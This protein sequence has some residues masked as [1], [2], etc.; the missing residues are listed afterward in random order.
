MTTSGPQANPNISGPGSTGPLYSSDQPEGVK[1]KGNVRVGDSMESTPKAGPDTSPGVAASKPTLFPPE[2]TNASNE[3]KE[4]YALLA[5]AFSSIVGDSIEALITANKDFTSR[6]TLSNTQIKIQ[7]ADTFESVK[8]QEHVQKLQHEI[9]KKLKGA[10]FATKFL[11]Y[12]MIAVTVVILTVA[13]VGSGG[14][15]S[16]AVVPVV[17]GEAALVASESAGAGAAA[18]AEVGAASGA[19]AAAGAAGEAVAT[20]GAAATA[21]AASG[22]ALAGGSA[23]SGSAAASGGAAGTEATA[24]GAQSSLWGSFKEACVASKAW[25]AGLTGAQ[26]FAV[27][28]AAATV[29]SSPMLVGGLSDMAKAEMQDRLAKQQE[30]LGPV[31]ARLAEDGAMLKFIQQVVQ[32]ESKIIQTLGEQTPGAMKVFADIFNELTSMVSASRK[33]E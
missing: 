16:G 15:A 25:F 8:K 23:A 33:M 12:L 32:K 13:I 1:K 5:K 6:A 18:G 24:E 27:G 11:T 21:A 4:A 28:T 19:G 20:E 22:D 29:L 2:V 30:L 9:Q 26:Q 7:L 17:E 31:M 3:D 14:A 10:D